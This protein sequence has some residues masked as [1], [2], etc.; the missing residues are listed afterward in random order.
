[1]MNVIS[2]DIP[3]HDTLKYHARPAMQERVPTLSFSAYESLKNKGIDIIISDGI[4]KAVVDLYET[5]YNDLINIMNRVVNIEIKPII[6]AFS[7]DNFQRANLEIDS[8]KRNAFIPNDPQELLSNQKY[9]N[10][11]AYIQGYRN[12][13]FLGLQVESLQKS[14]RAL[15]LIKDELGDSE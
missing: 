2:Q 12:R 10:V 14:E 4:Q 7:V 8:E 5:N 11:L 3:W 1:M 6:A 15:Q 13:L 9:L